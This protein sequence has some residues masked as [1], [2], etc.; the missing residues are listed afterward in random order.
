VALL[1]SLDLLQEHNRQVGT[2]A[3]DGQFHPI[4]SFDDLTHRLQ[5]PELRRKIEQGFNQ[6]LLV[7]FGLPLSRLFDAWRRGLLRNEHL[8]QPHG[9][10]NRRVPVFIWNGYE[11]EE[12]VYSPQ[13]FAPD[14]GGRTKAQ[15]LAADPAAAWQVL[16]SEG[17]LVS[18][19]YRGRGQ[20]VAG[21]TQ[22][23]A[24]RTPAQYLIS[25]REAGEAGWTAEAYV[26]AFLTQME[27][28]GCPLDAG[29]LSYLTASYAPVRGGVLSAHW[30]SVGQA[31]MIG[32][33]PGESIPACGARAAVRVI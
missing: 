29:T 8:L 27:R 33:G 1:A 28:A 21:R 15:V 4:P 12:L 22:V 13:H 31:G 25:L 10:L 30:S 9:G 7:P 20:T 16:L 6:L 17:A 24:G 19:P 11:S 3:I 14:H 18:L 23:E 2:T 26:T 5:S 32:R